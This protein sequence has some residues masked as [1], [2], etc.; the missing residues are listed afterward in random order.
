MG[1]GGEDSSQDPG[2]ASSKAQPCPRVP[3]EGT[4]LTVGCAHA[5]HL[6]V[7]IIQLLLQLLQ[8]LALGVHALVVLAGLGRQVPWVSYPSLCTVHA[9]L[10]APKER[11]AELPSFH[12]ICPL[13][14]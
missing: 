1:I 13:S 6:L 9:F 4:H 14:P 2:C 10:K 11:F 5:G 12:P 7:K 8:L 3:V